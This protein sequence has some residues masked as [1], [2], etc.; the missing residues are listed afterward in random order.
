MGS[1]SC[2]FDVSGFASEPVTVVIKSLK[3]PVAEQIK[4]H[5]H[6]RISTMD[7]AACTYNKFQVQRYE[8][9]QTIIDRGRVTSRTSNKD[10]TYLERIEY[11]PPISF[12]NCQYIAKNQQYCI[13][14][15][16]SS[17]GKLNQFGRLHLSS[18]LM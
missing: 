1:E 12:L 16:R 5:I 3:T 17:T 7:L 10:G 4:L 2:K 15:V 18:R 6:P 9:L 11:G 8:G 14:V 13:S